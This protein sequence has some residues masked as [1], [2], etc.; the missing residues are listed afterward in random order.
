[1]I[2]PFNK[3]DFFKEYFYLYVQKETRNEVFK[4]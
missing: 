1:M 4:N 2:N 3:G